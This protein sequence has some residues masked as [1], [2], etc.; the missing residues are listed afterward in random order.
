[1]KEESFLIGIQE[2]RHDILLI[3]VTAL[4]ILFASGLA[5]QVGAPP[6]PIVIP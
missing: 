4:I 3:I 5:V 1:M 6:T 2:R